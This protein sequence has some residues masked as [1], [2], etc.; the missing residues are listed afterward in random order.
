MR[1]L[2]DRSLFMCVCVCVLGGRG[3]GGRVMGWA[4]PIF[5]EKR[6]GLKE[7]FTMIGGG[8]LCVPDHSALPEFLIL[9]RSYFFQ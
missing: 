9:E 4:R 7:N 6:G 3:G 8:S 1:L 2:R 5:L